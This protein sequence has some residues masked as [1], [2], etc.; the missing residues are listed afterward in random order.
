[1]SLIS[2]VLGFIPI[3]NIKIGGNKLIAEMWEHSYTT[4]QVQL[5]KKHEQSVALPSWQEHSYWMIQQNSKL[6]LMRYI[7]NIQLQCFK[8]SFS[9]I[10]L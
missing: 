9:I 7:F 3:C 8:H 2:I 4:K 6:C 5:G 10:F 1:M